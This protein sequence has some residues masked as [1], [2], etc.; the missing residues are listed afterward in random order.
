VI[1]LV[2][3][4]KRLL[5]YAKPYKVML[6]FGLLALV[7]ANLLK[8]AVP[9]AIQQSVDAL[10]GQITHSQLLRYSVM[11][12]ALG[13]LQSGFVFA[14]SRLLLGAAHSME[15]DI[16]NSFYEHLQ[17]MSLEFFQV[18]RTGELM[19]QATRDVALAANATTEALMSSANAIVALMIILPLMALLSWRLTLLAF[20]PMVLVLIATS[21]FQRPM[22][23]RYAKVGESYARMCAQAHETLSGVKT[24]RAYLQEG[25]AVEAF[26]NLSRQC[27]DYQLGA[28][29]LSN[30]LNPV[31]QFFVGLSL[32]AVLWYGGD[33]TAAGTL[34]IG[35]FLE[36]I[37]Y[38]AYLAGPMQALGRQLAVL[39]RGV[40]SM[41]RVDSVLSLEPAI[42]D[43]LRP[44]AVPGINGTLEFRNVTF[45]YN[46]METPAID[47]ISFRIEQGQIVGLAG[48][49]GSG[50][51]TLMSMVPRLLAPCSGDV[52]IDGRSVREFPLKVLRSSIGYVPQ[53][54]FLFSDTIA[55]N[56]AF[57]NNQALRE[58]IEQ[59]AADSGVDSDIV[60]FPQG[61][62]TA[63][64]ERGVTL[65][66][67]QKQRVS[68]ARAI[69]LHPRILLLDDALS[70]V[71]SY[72]EERILARLRKRMQ[73]KTCLISSHRISTLR[74]ADV[75][76]VLHEGR[77]VEQGT[78]GKLLEQRGFYS[79]MY[80]TQMLEE[81]LAAG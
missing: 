19:T 48:L 20:A 49:V 14:Q 73:G 11:V 65:S 13:L 45:K 50:K 47:D 30:L 44:A 1:L 71:D 26:T 12:I 7:A 22:K 59:A 68:I 33:L 61:Y 10:A 16:R 8:A 52:L 3:P 74:R 32:I 76:I 55:A 34:S 62:E 29:R 56:I 51:S 78:H 18:N 72:T 57:G 67:G 24:I 66:G 38:V 9:L 2:S 79:E 53:E 36:F 27:V 5:T 42:Q 69:L 6:L 40:V 43:P 39:Q 4:F 64:G 21:V 46:G 60:A 15:R 58:G 75:I 25:A 35:Q 81:N 17:K 41:R 31:L 80:A 77:I 37:L 63:V 28:V 23:A 70:S 54:T